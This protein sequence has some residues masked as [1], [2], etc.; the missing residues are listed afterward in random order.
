[1]LQIMDSLNEV[2]NNDSIIE[3]YGYHFNTKVSY[4][5]LK[6]LQSIIEKLPFVKKLKFYD[7]QSMDV[8]YTKS[9]YTEIHYRIV[10]NKEVKK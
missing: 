3:E 2:L 7:E 9:S 1:M 8:Y 4:R 5:E 10:I 6:Q